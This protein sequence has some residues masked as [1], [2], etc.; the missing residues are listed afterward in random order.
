MYTAPLLRAVMP[1]VEYRDQRG[2][3]RNTKILVYDKEFQVAE[4]S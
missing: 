4:S 1:H 2:G 3:G